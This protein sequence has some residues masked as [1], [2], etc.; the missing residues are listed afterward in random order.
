MTPADLAGLHARCFLT[1]PPWSEASFAELLADPQITLLCDP[2]ARGF[3]VTRQVLDEAELLTLAVDPD[4]RRQGIARALID[5]MTELAA[6]RHIETLF[7]EV[8][9]TN[10][11]ARALYDACGFAAAGR[12][13]GYYKGPDGQ[14][15]A[16]LVLRKPLG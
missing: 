14:E 7:L 2:H 12:R 5:R 6:D 10:L 1:P 9:E 8:A 15:I 3:A 13:P 16:A 4:H 11:A